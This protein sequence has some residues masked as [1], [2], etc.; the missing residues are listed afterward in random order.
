MVLDF[1][2]EGSWPVMGLELFCLMK[3]KVSTGHF[4]VS[5]FTYEF[6]EAESVR[7]GEGS[8]LHSPRPLLM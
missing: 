4:P 2:M 8:V 1:S 6:N 7:Y 5:L 3:I